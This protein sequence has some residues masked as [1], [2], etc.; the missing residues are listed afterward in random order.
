[1]VASASKSKIAWLATRQNFQLTIAMPN[2]DEDQ[3]RG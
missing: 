1:M 2:E 3:A